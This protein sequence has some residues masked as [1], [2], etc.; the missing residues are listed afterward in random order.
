[1]AESEASPAAV[2]WVVY[3]RDGGQCAFVDELLFRSGHARVSSPDHFFLF[4]DWREN[5]HSVRWSRTPLAPWLLNF[6]VA[7]ENR[8]A[9]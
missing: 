9:S 1:M 8:P 3:E 7:I 4:A 5:S 6:L 2:K